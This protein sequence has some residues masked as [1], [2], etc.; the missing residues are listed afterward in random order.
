MVFFVL[1]FDSSVDSLTRCASPPESV[2]ACC[3]SL[4]YPRPTSDNVSSLFLIENIF[5][6]KVEPLQQTN[7]TL[8][9]C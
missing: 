7:L 6:K 2:V 3:P 5:L 1:V 8:Q 4:I 9:Q